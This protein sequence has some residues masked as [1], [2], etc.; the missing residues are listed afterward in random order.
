MFSLF[1]LRKRHADREGG[2]SLIEILVVVLIIGILAAIA[3]PMFLNQR[4]AANAASQKSD[5]KQLTSA[6][7]MLQTKKPNTIYAVTN[8]PW[9]F[10]ECS[11][12]TQDPAKLDPNHGCWV[13]YRNVLKSISTAS[14][15]NVDNLIDP[16]GR[17]Y[18]IN[19]N[20]LEQSPTDC[21]NDIIGYWDS[22]Y[23][24]TLPQNNFTLPMVSNACR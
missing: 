5:M 13:K 21:R 7:S 15:I 4:Q 12:P 16:Y 8:D 24:G 20:E 18:Y 17:P 22:N 10:N 23:N 2:F 14:G 1:A 3:V 6:I 9:S 11:G 19:P